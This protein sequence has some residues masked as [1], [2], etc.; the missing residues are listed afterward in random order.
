MSR[1]CRKAVAAGGPPDE[2]RP[3]P[4]AMTLGSGQ[5]APA[6]ATPHAGPTAGQ[7]AIRVGPN[8]SGG[9]GPDL[10]SETSLQRAAGVTPL[11]LSRRHGLVGTSSE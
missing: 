1:S 8:D 7:D 9:G 4:S 5:A 11:R 10:A 3:S 6:A 2:L